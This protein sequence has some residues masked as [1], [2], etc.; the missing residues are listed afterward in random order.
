MF[1]GVLQDFLDRSY[2][3]SCVSYNSERETFLVKVPRLHIPEVKVN[4]WES[5]D[6]GFSAGGAAAANHQVYVG[7]KL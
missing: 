3:T 5:H 6:C 7:N 4:C 2:Y 1:F